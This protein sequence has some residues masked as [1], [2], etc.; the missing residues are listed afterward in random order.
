MPIL[1]A[2]PSHHVFEAGLDPLPG[3]LQHEEP[4]EEHGNEKLKESAPAARI[5]VGMGLLRSKE[6]A[7]A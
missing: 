2:L 5:E 6:T 7:E 3:H 4:T 1:F